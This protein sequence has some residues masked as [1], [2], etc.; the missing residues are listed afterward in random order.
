MTLP[1]PAAR[2]IWLSASLVLLV[3]AAPPAWGD[4]YLYLGGTL[5][6]P[7]AAFTV[8]ETVPPVGIYS[9]DASPWAGRLLCT[10]NQFHLVN[11]QHNP[12]NVSGVTATPITTVHGTGYR[13]SA[14]QASAGVQYTADLYSASPFG[15]TLITLWRDGGWFDVPVDTLYVHQGGGSTEWGW[16]NADPGGGY[17]VEPGGSV[18]LDGR[19]STG[20]LNG[21]DSDGPWQYTFPIQGNEHLAYWSINGTK[22]AF[23]L[24]PTVTYEQIVNGLTLGPGT[25]P[26][27]FSL[28]GFDLDSDTASTTLTVLP[29]PAALVLWALAAGGIPRIRRRLCRR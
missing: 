8:G 9:S 27:Q 4:L 11:F 3:A 20:T 12:L 28:A 1:N 19:G 5:A 15:R 18:A 21:E 25:Y 23:G 26:L 13:M 22:I 6:G 24:N 29:E 10:T 14:T 7:S 2:A 16:Y 17:S